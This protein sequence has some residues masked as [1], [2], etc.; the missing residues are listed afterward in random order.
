MLIVLLALILPGPLR[1]QEPLPNIVII[2][3]DD[4]GFAD[5]GCFGASG[6]TTPRID[7]MASEGMRFTSFYVAQSVCG[8][9]RAGLLTGCYPNRLGMLG[10]PSHR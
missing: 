2:F 4:Q 10:A 9:S 1:A 8:A 3:T 5:L 7:R 6:F